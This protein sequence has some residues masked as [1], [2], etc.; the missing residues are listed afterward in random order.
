[1]DFR[2]RESFRQWTVLFRIARVLLKPMVV[3]AWHLGFSCKIDPRNGERVTADRSDISSNV[4]H[5]RVQFWLASSRDKYIRAF[6]H[7]SLCA[8]QTNAAAATSDQRDFSFELAHRFFSSD[9]S[10][11]AAST[12][13]PSTLLSKALATSKSPP[14]S[15]VPIRLP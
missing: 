14:F 6:I 13:R 11:C 7:E 12:K 10:H 1:M 4:L 2:R 15:H 3:N 9:V 8:R 5:S